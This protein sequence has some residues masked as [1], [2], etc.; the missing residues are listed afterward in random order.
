MSDIVIKK[1]DLKSTDVNRNMA[2][3]DTWIHDTADKINYRIA[4]QDRLSEDVDAKIAALQEALEKATE[5]AANSSG[6]SS[7]GS[8][9]GTGD[10]NDLAN[11]PQI[12]GVTLSGNKFLSELN[13]VRIT[14]TDIDGILAT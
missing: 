12:E 3:V 8:V 14:D 5:K 4:A 6:E 10:Y 2:M 9:E 7:G 11:K 1:P 13:L